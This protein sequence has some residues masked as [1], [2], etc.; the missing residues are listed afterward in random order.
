VTLV[1]SR[2]RARNGD[3]VVFTGRV[4]GGPIP[5]A[6]KLLALQ[7][8]TSKGWRTFATPRARASDGRFS[9]RYRFTSVVSH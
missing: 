8:H 3:D 5:E 7:A 4:L 2:K 6:G 1:P 9:S